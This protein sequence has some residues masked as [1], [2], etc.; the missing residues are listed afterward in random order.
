M[1]KIVKSA[2]IKK[3]GG[4]FFI[5]NALE[6]VTFPCSSPPSLR[7][8]SPPGVEELFAHLKQIYWLTNATKTQE[9]GPHN[10]EA[11]SFLGIRLCYKLLSS[12]Y[13]SHLTNL[14]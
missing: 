10:R 11:P 6:A 4:L 7:D 1:I 3:Y 5:N 14:V 13:A 2:M 12:D 8:T 9:K